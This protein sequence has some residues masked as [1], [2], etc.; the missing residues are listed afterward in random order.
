LINTIY[1]IIPASAHINVRQWADVDYDCVIT[2][3]SYYQL[4]RFNLLLDFFA[5]AAAS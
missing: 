3:Q 5:V 4:F 2:E 1:L